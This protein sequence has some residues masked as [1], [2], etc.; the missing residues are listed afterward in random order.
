MNHIP[1]GLVRAKK[2]E[3]IFGTVDTYLIWKLTAG[4][5]HVTDATNAA[6]TM[7]FNIRE[8]CWDE[9]ICNLM[10][11]PMIMLPKVL[12]SADYF[13]EVEETIFG[14]KI[15]IM[16]VA[17]DQQAATLGQACVEPGM[18]KS[19]YGT[20]CFSLMNTGPRLIRSKNK[21]LSTIA[22][23][24]EGKTTYALEGSIFVAGAVIQWLRDEMK[25]F[26]SATESDEFAIKADPDQKIYFVPAFTGLGAPYWDS[27][28]RGAI[29]GLLRDT[30]REEIALAALESIGFQTRDLLEAMCKDLLGLDIQQIKLR[31]DGGMTQSSEAMQILADLSGVEINIPDIQESTAKGVAWLAGMKQG[32]YSKKED[33]SK[34]WKVMKTFSP[35]ISSQ[36]KEI[37]YSGWVDA[38]NK[39]RKSN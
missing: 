33:Y 6:R 27:E 38:V 23:R 20:G 11:V 39:T 29:F 4:R 21:M 24:L 30:G 12:D 22:Y 9:E 17:G 36:E 8:N 1:D 37:K 2:G 26:N 19:T 14:A 10:D 35:N 18:I 25:F 16:G 32:L 15:P 31:V 5:A 28:A 13:G 3:L 7:L 34:D